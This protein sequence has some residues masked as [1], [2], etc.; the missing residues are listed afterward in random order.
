MK[1]ENKYMYLCLKNIILFLNYIMIIAFLG[2]LNYLQIY[3]K[4]YQNNNYS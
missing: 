4:I 3:A 1:S 2:F